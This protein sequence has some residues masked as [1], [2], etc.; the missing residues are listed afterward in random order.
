M[1]MIKTFG[2]GLLLGGSALAST[3]RAQGPEGII[4][5]SDNP[6]TRQGTRGAPFLHLTVGARAN[7]MAGAVNSSV[8]GPTAW[9]YNP[10]GASATEGFSISAGRQN[11][12]DDFGIHQSFA[13]L[14]VPLLGGVIGLSLNTLNSG[15][16]ERT[17]EVDPFGST[18][19]G[20][21]F[22][23][24]STAVGLGYARRLTDRLSVGTQLKLINEG[25]SDASLSWVSA[26]FGTQF[27]TGIYGIMIGGALQHVGGQ[28]AMNGALIQRTV[29][30]AELNEQQTTANLE[31]RDIDL[32]TSFRFSLGNNLYGT[33]ESLFGAGNG[34]HALY[35]EMAVND[36]VDLAPQLAF[37]GEYGFR[38]IFFARGG[39][40]FFNDERAAGVETKGSYGLSGGFGLRL[41]VAGRA[42]RFDYSFT[43]LGDL[44]NIQVF[45]L[46]FG[47]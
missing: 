15:D 23:W 24:T 9:F 19:G 41:P 5:T 6:P 42:A 14:S 26:D 32:P 12:Y 20:Q 47:R 16:I 31:T 3:A 11:L 17:Q 46:E 10:A 13:A 43:S 25:I 27:A 37:G 39:K 36:A 1:R 40:R 35:A 28:S 34:Q 4:P 2:L 22:T 45:S 33:A 21:E 38:N 29:N 44:Q 8:V 30:D 18:Q 7:A